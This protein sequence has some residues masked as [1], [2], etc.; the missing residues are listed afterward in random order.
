MALYQ[1]IS[2]KGLV[3]SLECRCTFTPFMNTIMH[4]DLVPSISSTLYV[5]S[6]SEPAISLASMRW[7]LKLLSHKFALLLES[8]PPNQTQCTLPYKYKEMLEINFEGMRTRSSLVM[9][10]AL[11]VIALHII[12]HVRR[13]W[14][15]QK[16]RSV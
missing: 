3:G 11:L 5:V 16:E 12:H 4:W 15:F 10:V 6:S 13:G 1:C 9:V 7:W 14:Y 2:Y 8:K